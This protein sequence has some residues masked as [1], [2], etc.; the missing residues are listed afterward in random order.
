VKNTKWEIQKSCS[1]P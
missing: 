1:S